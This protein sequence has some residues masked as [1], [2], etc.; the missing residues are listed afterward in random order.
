MNG[1]HIKFYKILNKHLSE[2]GYFKIYT[3]SW[4]GLME[5]FEDWNSKKQQLIREHEGETQAVVLKRLENVE[6]AN[7]SWLEEVCNLSV[8]FKYV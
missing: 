8:L 7:Q 1:Y 6:S 3:A 2:G 5:G 4:V